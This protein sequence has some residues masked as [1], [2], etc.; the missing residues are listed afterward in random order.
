MPNEE[1][2]LGKNLLP[3]KKPEEVVH[4]CDW[5]SIYFQQISEYFNMRRDHE[6]NNEIIATFLNNFMPKAEG[7]LTSSLK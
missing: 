7:S 1:I 2:I 6:Y 4:A 5:N 3:P